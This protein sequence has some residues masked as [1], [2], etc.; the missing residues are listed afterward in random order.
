[1]TPAWN[2]ENL[3]RLATKLESG[4]IFAHGGTP[5]VVAGGGVCGGEG[6]GSSCSHAFKA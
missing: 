3:N 2:N 1:M 5:V 6:G 4:L